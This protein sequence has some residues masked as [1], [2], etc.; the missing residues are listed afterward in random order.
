LLLNISP[1][2]EMDSFPGPLEQVL[3]NFFNNS[4]MHAF[5]D[6]MSGTISIKARQNGGQVEIEY[7]DNGCGMNSETAAHAFDPFFTT[8]LGNGG[9]GLGLY[10]VF[11]LVT[12]VLGGEVR[13]ES[14]PGSGTTFR[15][16]L[17]LIAPTQS[18][19]EDK[20]R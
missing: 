4:L 8:R 9:S 5:D 19:V 16:R 18:N 11:N 1:N 20:Y 12:A 15:L 17:P 13:M 10:I 7:A 3:L 2:I 14:K 6:E